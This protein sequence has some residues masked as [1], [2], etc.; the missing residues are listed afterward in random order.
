MCCLKYEEEA[1]EELVKNVPKPDSFVDT[2]AGKGSV[3]DVN[4]LKSTVRVRLEDVQEM[5]IKT[6]RADEVT[7]LGGKQKRAEYLQ[8]K[9]EGKLPDEKPAPKIRRIEKP[10]EPVPAEPVKP[11]KSHA[12]RHRNHEVHRVKAEVESAPAQHAEEPKKSDKP[13]PHNRRFRRRR[14][15]GGEKSHQG[16]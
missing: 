1:Y 11:E 16:E 15:S 14:P 9:A 12:P 2:P 3:L 7:V 10:Q 5:N 13:Q 4:L 6:F 8:M